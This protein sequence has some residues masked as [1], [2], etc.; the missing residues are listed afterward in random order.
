MW[1]LKII[2]FF[3]LNLIGT[4][5]QIDYLTFFP[6]KL[7][8]HNKSNYFLSLNLNNHLQ[9][10]KKNFAP[11]QNFVNLNKFSELNFA[12]IFANYLYLDLLSL[13]EFSEVI[14]FT[15]FEFSYGLNPWDKK[16]FQRIKTNFDIAGAEVEFLIGVEKNYPLV[17]YLSGLNLIIDL[18]IIF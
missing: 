15:D 14:E 11:K 2:I 1:H 8:V 12:Q 5:F 17:N 13:E 7:M 18:E 3:N 10:A 16:I 9:Q 4:S 6:S